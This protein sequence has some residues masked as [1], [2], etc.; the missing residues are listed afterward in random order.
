MFANFIIAFRET[1]EAALV[2]GI[3]VSCLIKSGYTRYQ[4]TLYSALA[5]GIGGSLIG[6][7]LLSRLSSYF[8]GGSAE[9][10][11]EAVI[12]LIGASLLIST[13]FWLHKYRTSPRYLEKQVERGLLHSYPQMAIFGLITTAV[14]REGIEMVVFLNAVVAFKNTINA[15]SIVSGIAL[16]AGLGYFVFL[17][18]LKIPLKHFFAVTNVLLTLFA[19]SL[20][21][22][23]IY[24]IVE[25]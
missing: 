11:F 17:T 4:W 6:A 13:I 2:V 19:V 7:L 20:I 16:A 21:A 23:G 24:E 1:L 9:E 8:S 18:S 25:L 14:L 22:R 5:F 15:I 3:I 12:M 10:I